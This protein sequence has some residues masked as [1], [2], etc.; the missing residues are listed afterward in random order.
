[1]AI[2]TARLTCYRS[3][4]H[5]DNNYLL[6]PSYREQRAKCPYSN[7]YYEG[8]TE[9]H[10]WVFLYCTDDRQTDSLR[11]IQQRPLFKSS[12]RRQ[13]IN[14]KSNLSLLKLYRYV[15]EYSYTGSITLNLTIMELMK[16]CTFLLKCKNYFQHTGRIYTK[17]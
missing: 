12:V 11:S 1:M 5:R 7:Y 13:F 16:Y 10:S 4:I 3:F 8:R 6:W 2:N 17:Q 15:I 9:S 14:C